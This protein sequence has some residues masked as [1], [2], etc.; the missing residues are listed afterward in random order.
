MGK[1]FNTRLSKMSILHD[2]NCFS[3]DTSLRDGLLI[4]FF[5]V[6]PILIVIVIAVIKRDAIKRKF[7]RK[8]RRQHR[9]CTYYKYVFQHLGACFK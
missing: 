2:C 3:L 6:L 7:C 5:L 9:Y 1:R 4:F 8:S